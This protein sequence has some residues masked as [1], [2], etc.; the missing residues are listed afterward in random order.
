MS[1]DSL[2]S[3]PSHPRRVFLLDGSGA[4]LS[5]VALMAVVIPLQPSFGLPLGLLRALASVATVLAAYSLCC[6]LGLRKNF[7]PFLLGIASAN[8]AY[9]LV[10]MSALAWHRLEITGLC[11]L[12]FS[13]E[14]LVIAALVALELETAR[15]VPSPTRS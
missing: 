1:W 14:T 2:K 12:Y 9:C 15:R 13:L 10:T 8:T 5:V 7:R 11:L 6:S 3:L 4:L